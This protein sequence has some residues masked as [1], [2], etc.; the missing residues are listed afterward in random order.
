MGSDVIALN[1]LK[2]LDSNVI[3]NDCSMWIL[4]RLDC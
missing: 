1:F 2:G 4:E 3:G